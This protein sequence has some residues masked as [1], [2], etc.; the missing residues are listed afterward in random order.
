MAEDPN[1]SPV[2]FHHVSLQVSKV[3]K[4]LMVRN[5][6][7]EIKAVVNVKMDFDKSVKLLAILS[8]QISAY[9]EGKG[10]ITFSLEGD[11]T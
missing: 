2:D 9:E 5:E 1:K 11:F 3:S 4:M 7:Q 8:A 10:L 6:H